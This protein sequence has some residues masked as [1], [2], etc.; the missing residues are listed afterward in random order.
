MIVRY[1]YKDRGE[2]KVPFATVV[3][4]DKLNFGVSVC[5]E[6]DSFSK[7]RGRQIAMGRAVTDYASSE[8][9]LSDMRGTVTYEGQEFTRKELVGS[10]VERAARAAA[11]YYKPATEKIGV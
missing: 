2:H 5:A 9:I 7:A 10:A 11:S 1:A 8:G 4:I 6:G 3:F